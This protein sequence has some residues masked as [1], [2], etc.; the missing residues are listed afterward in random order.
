MASTGGVYKRGKHWWIRY[1]VGG[2]QF[3]EAT[4]TTQKE[5]GKALL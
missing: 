5:L 4:R 2:R 3:R 1:S